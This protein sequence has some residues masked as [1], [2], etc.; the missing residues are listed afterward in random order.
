MLKIKKNKFI[1]IILVKNIKNKIKFFDS[2]FF[3]NTVFVQVI[4]TMYIE[5][6]INVKCKYDFQNHVVFALVNLK[7]NN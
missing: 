1:N 3:I 7:H 4:Y 6:S 5:L 2:I